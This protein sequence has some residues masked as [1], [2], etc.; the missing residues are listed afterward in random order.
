[1][2]YIWS[3][4]LSHLTN[5]SLYSLIYSSSFPRPT[6]SGNHHSTLFLW[7]WLLLVPHVSENICL[8]FFVWLILLSMLPSK[9]IRL[10]TKGRTFFFLWLNNIPFYVYSSS[11]SS[12]HLWMEICLFPSWLLWIMLQWAWGMQISVPNNDLISFRYMPRR[13]ITGSYCNFI[14]MFFGGSFILF[15]IVAAPM[16]ILASS[17]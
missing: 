3:S 10:V 8:S 1:M 12:I 5:G 17:A 4:E 9:S 13:G 16:Y 7:V 15:S 14:L 2:L 11:P 6:A